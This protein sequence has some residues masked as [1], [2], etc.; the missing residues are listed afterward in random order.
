ME[1]FPIP[2]KRYRGNRK[3]SHLAK[4]TPSEVRK[5][6]NLSNNKVPQKLLAEKF[7]VSQATISNLLQ[8][9]IYTRVA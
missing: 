7:Q 8:G 3:V 5:I 4:L 6:R 2:K 9:K 1:D